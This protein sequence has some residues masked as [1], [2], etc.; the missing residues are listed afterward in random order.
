MQSAHA[1]RGLKPCPRLQRK[2]RGDGWL[3]DPDPARI[4]AGDFG[5]LT[6]GDDGMGEAEL[7]MD[8]FTLS[9]GP[10]S[11]NDADGTAIIVH[12]GQDDLV[13]HPSGNS[14]GRYACG[15]VAEPMMAEMPPREA[16]AEGNLFAPAHVPFEEGLVDQLQVPEGFTI[17]AYAQG[18]SNPRM[19]A[20]SPSG[21]VYVTET[22]NNTVRALADTDGDGVIDEAVAV[23]VNLPLVHGIAFHE[24]QVF[25][26]GEKEV[27]V[28]DVQDDGSF[29][30]LQ[31]ILDSLPD[32][33]QHPRRTI[34]I[35][36]DGQL[37]LS[38][39]S[40]CNACRETNPLSATMLR[41]NLDGSD[42]VIVASGLRNTLG[43]DWEPETGEMW[44]M[45]QGSDWRGDEQPPEELNQIIEGG[46]YGWPYCYGNQ[47]VDQYL[48]CR[49]LAPP[50]SNTARTR[51]RRR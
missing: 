50:P 35:G 5:N 47:E 29:A 33:G 13:S 21:V 31:V 4:L 41:A 40:S 26:A 9:D 23:G 48:S 27:W 37:Y 16:S 3:N 34:A 12:V 39:G 32:G 42:P 51:W 30:N 11:V 38:L 24:D 44:G 8:T 20:V 2:Q 10:T 18:L 22:E 15:V 28:A 19:L 45:D 1:V 14:G 6:V 7:T 17:E 46:N 36:T 43:W 25:L 49:R